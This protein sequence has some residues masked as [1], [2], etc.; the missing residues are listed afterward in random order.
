MTFPICSLACLIA[1]A[2]ANNCEAYSPDPA[3]AWGG[4]PSCAAERCLV[5]ISWVSSC[6][7]TGNSCLCLNATFIAEVAACT[8]N[9]CPSDGPQVYATYQS[10][11][12][13]NGGYTISVSLEQ[14][15]EFMNNDFSNLFA[16]SLPPFSI[17]T[18]VPSV[19][20]EN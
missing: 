18:T 11:C 10:N 3:G 14:W 19:S 7:T 2:F 17:T 15:A 5:P 1:L 6:F 20:F 12:L 13:S 9:L 4:Y 16:P 8:G